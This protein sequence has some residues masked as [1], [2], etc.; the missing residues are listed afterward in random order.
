MTDM[1][2]STDQKAPDSKVFEA[3]VHALAAGL[4]GIMVDRVHHYPMTVQYEDTDAGGIVYHANY[5]N[6]AE[7]GRSALLRLNGIDLQQYLDAENETIVIA[8]M[9]LE[10]MRP[11]K[12]ND[13]LVIVSHLKAFS[14]VRAEIDQQI[15]S[16]D[17]G[18]IFARVIVEGVWVNIKT[19]PKRWPLPVREK[20]NGFN[21]Q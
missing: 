5:V 19:G 10:F 13:R 9:Q 6:F 12:L 7:R 15:F 1:M 20:M 17:K 14:G 8:K 11:A 4:D 18:H 3:D 21:N 2:K 16:L